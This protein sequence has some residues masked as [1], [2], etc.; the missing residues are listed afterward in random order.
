[1]MHQELPTQPLIEGFAAPEFQDVRCEFE[2]NF[3]ERGEQGAAFAVYL[4]GEKVV[5]LWGGQRC[6][7]TNLPWT[8]NTLALVF[9]VSKG[10][11]AAAMAVAHSRGLFELDDP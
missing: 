3:A 10:M 9:S 8:N 2:R 7:S 6:T 11:A 5:D 1:M 4:R